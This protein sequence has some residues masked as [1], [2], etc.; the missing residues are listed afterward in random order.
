MHAL[1]I[2]R[3]DFGEIIASSFLRRVIIY[4]TLI[5]C[6]SKVASL[7]NQLRS[8]RTVPLPDTTLPNPAAKHNYPYGNHHSLS[9]CMSE[10]LRNLK[11]SRL[12]ASITSGSDIPGLRRTRHPR[13]RQSR[14]VQW[15]AVPCHIKASSDFP[16]QILAGLCLYQTAA[17]WLRL[18]ALIEDA[19]SKRLKSADCCESPGG[20]IGVKHAQTHQ[21]LLAQA[22]FCP[23]QKKQDCRSADIA[24]YGQTNV[25]L[26]TA[27]EAF[28]ESLTKNKHA[29]PAVRQF[30]IKRG[31]RN[32]D[33]PFCRY[34]HC[35]VCTTSWIL[36]IPQQPPHRCW[37]GKSSKKES[38]RWLVFHKG[39]VT[40]AKSS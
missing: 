36:Q 8:L 34:L 38:S 16:G 7:A 13:M 18:D 33:S 28:V 40:S 25:Y 9:T 12:S 14:S 10:P 4:H 37:S 29:V 15:C 2:C 30:Q 23:T 26:S 35:E 3:L 11:C 1:K 20:L 32:L 6:A 17:S 22:L 39:V 31:S 27:W 19:L 24:L 21:L 5:S